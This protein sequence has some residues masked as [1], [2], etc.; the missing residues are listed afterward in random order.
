MRT[1]FIATLLLT[2]AFAQTE[3]KGTKPDAD[4]AA[5]EKIDRAFEAA[6]AKKDV[7]AIGQMYHSQAHML[8]G[9]S[10]AAIG[11]DAIQK[12]W[13]GAFDANL[14][15]IKLTTDSVERHGDILVELGHYSS[16]FGGKPDNGK[17]VVLYKKEAGAWK[18]WVDSFSSDGPPA[19]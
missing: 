2:S 8:G 1:L 12:A 16:T 3:K 4:R 18:L 17:Y 10:P 9:G 15:D 14:A 19:Q 7:A 5:V 11:R 6:S 13:Q